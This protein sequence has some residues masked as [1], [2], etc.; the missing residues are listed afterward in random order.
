MNFIEQYFELDSNK[1]DAAWASPLVTNFRQNWDNLINPSKAQK[2]MSYLLSKQS[3]DNVMKMFKDPLKLG[4]E[5]IPIA[6]T[7]KLRNIII[8]ERQKS[9]IVANLNAIDTSADV[10]KKDDYLLLKHRREIEAVISNLQQQIG[11]PDYKLENEEKNGKKIFNGNIKEFDEMELNDTDDVSIDYFFNT[12]YKLDHEVHGQEAVNYFIRYN[13]MKDFIEPW[14]NNIMAFK[15]IAARTYVNEGSG[16]IEIKEIDP[17]KIKL[18]GGQK[19]NAKDAPCIGY[20]ERVTVIEF[21]RMMGN[22][23]DWGRDFQKMIRAVNFTNNVGLTGIADGSGNFYDSQNNIVCSINT[24]LEYYISIGYIEWKSIDADSYRVGTNYHGNFR[25]IPTKIT[26]EVSEKS[27]YK[28]ESYYK[29]VTYKSYYIV[30]GYSDQELFKFGKLYHQAISG[31]EDEYSSFSIIVRK[32]EG[33]SVAEI[34]KPFIDIAQELFYKMKWM[35]RKAKPQGRAYSYDS[36]IDVANKM[37]ASGN[38]KTDMMSLIKMFE[39]GLTEIYTYPNL[40]GRVLGGGNQPNYSIPNGVDPS[41]KT[42]SELLD[43]SV[44]Q[45]LDK[46]GISP[47]ASAYS[48][49]PNDG[50]K[51]QMQALQ[52]SRN[53]TYYIDNMIVGAIEDTAIFILSKVQDICR[54]KGT[55]PY[56]FLERAL[57]ADTVESF[58][59]LNG[60]SFHRYGIFIDTFNN[61]IERQEIKAETMDAWV[62]KEISYEVKK[63]IDA[64]DDPKK[65][66]KVLTFEKRKAMMEVKRQEQLM[67]ERAL[68]LDSVKTKNQI[69]VI[70]RKGSWDVKGK[71]IE[72]DSYVE[73]ARITAK[74]SIAKQQ[75]REENEPVKQAVRSQAKIKEEEAKRNLDAQS[76]LS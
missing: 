51:L 40:D 69:G 60:F 9:G 74:A 53:A 18:I 5:F 37:I 63:M 1:K 33:Q 26:R 31:T 20:E 58:T 43:W 64:I 71:Q 50:F 44:N 13:Q 72:A 2:N 55:L 3:M 27:Q 23:F 16:A 57:G 41:V 8:A 35:I 67:H 29:E 7:E 28:K 38:N 11:Y 48:P 76:P 45:I 61:D 36:L 30:T 39:E 46:L 6:I 52:Q 54:Y 49:N 66:V 4:F 32:T 65:A 10:E 22:D 34:A 19:S 68:E 17:S 21:V 73:A 24:F 14:C 42:F 59:N 62:K 15:A 25:M 47:L 70:D 12:H 56:M 75:M